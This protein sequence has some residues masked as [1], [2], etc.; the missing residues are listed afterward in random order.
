MHL[1]TANRLLPTS[2]CFAFTLVLFL[3]PAAF[4]GAYSISPLVIDRTMQARDAEDVAIT[5]QNSADIPVRLYPTVNAIAVDESGAIKEFVTPSMAD[6]RTTVTSWLAISRARIELAPGGSHEATLEIKLP[7]QVEPGTYHAF[8]GFAEGGNRPEAEAKVA[9][10]GVP[11]VVVSIEVKKDTVTLLR[12][13]RFFVDRFVT[14]TDEKKA[15]V[16]L[17]NGGSESIQPRG[18][19]I[20]YDT[21]GTEVAAVPFNAEEQSLE[22]GSESSFELALPENLRFGKYKAYLDLEYGGAQTAQLQDTTFFYIVPLKSLVFTFLGLLA[23]SLFLAWRVHSKYAGY[24]DDFEVVSTVPLT[25]RSVPSEAKDHDID[26]K[27]PQA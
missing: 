19:I 18:E 6:G 17:V 10:G 25:V 3:V 13:S 12:L 7:P 23:F 5:I 9:A 20:F 16:V 26:L 8:I 21:T 14:D 27:K 15:N 11:G 22:P 24:D 1:R 2:L 4:T